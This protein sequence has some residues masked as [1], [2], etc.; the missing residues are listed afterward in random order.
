MNRHDKEI[1]MRL[2]RLGNLLRSR[3]S[4]TDNR[5]EAIEQIRPR[6]T[7]RP[8]ALR[9]S[10]GTSGIGL[11]ACLLIGIGL[12][13][14]LLGPTP[15][16]LADVQKSIDSRPWVLVRYEDGT[17][18]W[19]NLQARCS[20][21]TRQDADG[22]NFYA[23]MRDHVNGIWRYYHSN[24]GR[25]IHEQEF[26]PRPYPQTPWE[27][28]VGDWDNRGARGS[29]RKTIEK[30]PDTI[31]GREVVR[32][33]TYDMGPLDLRCLAQQVWADPE[34]RL[35]LRIRKYSR[36]GSKIE[37]DTG[38]FSFPE[39]GPSSIYD[40]GAPQGLPLVTNWG[41]IEPAAEAVVEAAKKA[42]RDLPDRMR[43][44]KT[45]KYG[46][47]ITYRWGDRLRHESYGKTNATHN[48]VLP[49][50]VPEN[51]ENTRQWV[52]DNLTLYHMTIFD[53]Q[54]EYAYDSGDGLWDGPEDPGA[55]LHVEYRN[56]DWIDVLIPI[57][58]Q[59]PYTS[60]VGPMRVLE[61]EPGTPEGCVLLRYEGL[62]LRRDWYVDPNRDYI[63]VRQ[64]ECRRDQEDEQWI[65]DDYGQTARADLTQLPSGQW[66][67]RTV[68]RPAAMNG[69][70]EF[71]VT[72]LA[73]ADMEELTGA[74]DSAGFF[75]GE[76][77]LQ[78]AR[79]N[80]ARITFWAR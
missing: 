24:W 42:W 39:T 37:I 79:A 14:A 76:K 53:G 28:A 12:L 71:N 67:A 72:L 32:F 56:S 43:V 40:L 29:S 75:D 36:P 2:E 54:Y 17:K 20:F 60:N 5:M 44:V 9:L 58:D 23:G 45:S 21:Y 62:D 33:D 30:S 74:D 59:W 16:T 38:D 52:R 1:E 25:Q 31:D 41:V 77:L 48:D 73:D 15:L 69:A 22:G 51:I 19:A 61:D 49:V 4:I 13:F 8:V 27:Y 3:P 78:N 11:A 66:Y 10:L 26:T 18:E 70:T 34:T 64:S 47:S 57:R 6:R 50:E 63:C 7:P 55:R 80:T 46:L 35:P 68:N 65:E